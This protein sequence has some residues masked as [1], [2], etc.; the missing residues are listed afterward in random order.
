MKL[1]SMLERSLAWMSRGEFIWFCYLGDLI[2]S[3]IHK[4]EMKYSSKC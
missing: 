3:V 2:R 4:A 1:Q